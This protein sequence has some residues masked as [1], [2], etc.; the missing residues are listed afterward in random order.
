MRLLAEQQPGP[1]AA[2]AD[3][4]ALPAT[5]TPRLLILGPDGGTNPTAIAPSLLAQW[6]QDPQLELLGPTDDVRPY[7]RRADCVVLP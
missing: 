1:A 5:P 2:D 7:I 3:A 6:R 4:D